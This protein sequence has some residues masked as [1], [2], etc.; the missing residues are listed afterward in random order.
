LTNKRQRKKNQTRAT[1]ETPIKSIAQH[2]KDEF[3]R[4][5]RNV[6]NKLR[7]TKNTKGSESIVA[8]ENKEGKVLYDKVPLEYLL[9]TPYTRGVPKLKDI[10]SWEAF[11]AFVERGKDFTNRSAKRFQFAKNDSGV[12]MTEQAL[13]RAYKNN[14][15][16][17]KNAE[18]LIASK[19]DIAI[20]EGRSTMAERSY[21]TGTPTYNGIKVPFEFD[22]TKEK[23]VRRLLNKL[24]TM[25][26]RANDAEYY[27]WRN[28]IYK[29]NFK[30]VIQKAFNSDADYVLKLIDQL[31]A[32]DLFDMSAKY[33]ALNIDHYYLAHGII[34]SENEDL[35]KVE[36]YLEAYFL[37]DENMDLKGF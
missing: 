13:N 19:Q 31:D 34:R 37:G 33:D 7:Y 26:R 24:E 11:K 29:D 9:N 8:I 4:V 28:G 10:K 17:R 1:K 35:N 30:T 16:E 12:V 27:T 25:E 22:F 18:R 36:S 2:Q 3:N 23:D 5:R 20:A 15:I 32:G 21:Q 6:M 14:V